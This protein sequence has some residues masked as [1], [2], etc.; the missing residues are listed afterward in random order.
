MDL[1]SRL[2]LKIWI[3]TFVVGRTFRG[4]MSLWWGRCRQYDVFY[5]AISISTNG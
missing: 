4:M 2:L 1:I 3:L 5:T